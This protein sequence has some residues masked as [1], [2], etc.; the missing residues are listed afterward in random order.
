MMQMF[1]TICLI[2]ALLLCKHACGMLSLHTYNQ[3]ARS[4]GS[5]KSSAIGATLMRNP[6]PNVSSSSSSYT[7]SVPYKSGLQASDIR[8]PN[9][10]IQDA[11]KLASQDIN[12]LPWTNSITAKRTLS[13]MPMLQAQLDII[14]SLGMEEVSVE[15]KFV[16]R[17]S[18]VKPAKIGNMNFKSDKFRSVRLTYF[19][20]GDLVQEFNS[21]WYPAYEYDIPLLGIDLISL[22]KNRVLSVID[23]QPLH[24]TAEYHSKYIEPLGDI[25]AKYQDLQGTLSGKF[26]DD[27]SFFSK[28]MLFGRFVDESKLSNVVLPAYNEYLKA[29]VEL[30]SNAAPNH[31]AEATKV[32]LDRQTQYDIYSAVKDPAVGLF[33]TY[34]GKEWSASFVQDFLFKLSKGHTST[35][36]PVHNQQNPHPTGG[37]S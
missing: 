14:K 31:S 1:I 16:Y 24:P 3:L 27:T 34:F 36:L 35:S 26:Y 18:D 20:A 8:V 22:G 17:T 21:L 25:R 9:K 28:N 6:N 7:P 5:Y 2:N 4:R 33:D 37:H 19:D 11:L 13:Y 10:N 32:V 23:F 30:S 29:Y 12:A 15:E